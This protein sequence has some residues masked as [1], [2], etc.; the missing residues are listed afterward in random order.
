MNFPGNSGG[1][2]VAA[3]PRESLLNTV[4]TNSSSLKQQKSRS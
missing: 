1:L 2:E 4:G 3:L